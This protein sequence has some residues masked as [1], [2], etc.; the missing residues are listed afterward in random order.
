M[1]WK[2]IFILLTF[3]P[4]FCFA[5]E[6]DDGEAIYKLHCSPCH[7]NTGKG[8]GPRAVELKIKPQN[9]TNAS[10]MSTRTDRQLNNVI[11]NGGIS[12][13]KSPLMPA[14]KDK[15]SDKQIKTVVKYLRKLCSCK[16]ESIVSDSKLRAVD[17]EFR[18]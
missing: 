3:F 5:E 2:I 13:S 17:L 15:L 18:K 10:Y 8:N 11:R 9:H 6:L 12:I 7:G 4:S 1:R 16:F 14:W